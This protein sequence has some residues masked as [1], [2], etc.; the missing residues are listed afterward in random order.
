MLEITHI[1]TSI[2]KEVIIEEVT[3]D[4]YK[5]MTKGNFFFDWKLEKDFK[6]YKLVLVESNEILGL[7]SLDHVETETRFEIKL[8]AVS[9]QNRGHKKSYEGIA[10]NLI[11]FACREALKFYGE[12][13]FI[14]LLPKTRLRVHYMLNY[15]MREIGSQ[16]FLHQ[17]T[18][19]ELL[20]K[21]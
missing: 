6:V 12:E 15:N 1:A 9:R 2:R 3:V 8:L 10:G 18:M 16:L 13:A 19:R 20:K 11:A 4:D 5:V 21:Y 14:S 17:G 7:M